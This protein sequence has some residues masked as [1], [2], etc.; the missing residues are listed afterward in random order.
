MT[1]RDAPVH[2]WVPWIAWYSKHFAED[3]INR[4][5]SG[6]SVVLDPFA[7]VG[8]T[9]VEA[10]R[11]GAEGN[12]SMFADAPASLEALAV[13]QCAGDGRLRRHDQLGGD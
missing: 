3:A 8:T 7:G 2:R 11:V 6:P 12:A 10:D 4:Y 9:L 13:G 1:N 5:T